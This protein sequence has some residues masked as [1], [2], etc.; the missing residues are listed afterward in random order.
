MYVGDDESFSHK[1]TMKENKL[2]QKPKIP[3]KRVPLE[4]ANHT[5]TLLL[6]LLFPVWYI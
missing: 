1:M 2:N 4:R 5:T 3:E 6:L